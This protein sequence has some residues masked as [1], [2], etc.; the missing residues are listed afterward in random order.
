M[1]I[2][3]PLHSRAL[4][5]P[6]DV[7]EMKD[8][9]LHEAPRTQVPISRTHMLTSVAA[10]GTQV[11]MVLAPCGAYQVDVLHAKSAEIMAASRCVPACRLRT[12]RGLIPGWGNSG[13]RAL[14]IALATTGVVPS[15]K[16][17]GLVPT[18]ALAAG[19]AWAGCG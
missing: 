5:V 9:G 1:W 2:E 3:A 18:N 13:L 15:V 11:D 19:L 4:A 17:L 14:L 6:T 8:G 10:S 7:A 12:P 16:T